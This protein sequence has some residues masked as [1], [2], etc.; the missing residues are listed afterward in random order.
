VSFGVK[1]C[2]TYTRSNHCALEGFTSF[3]LH[4]SF[5]GL[6]KALKLLLHL[7]VLQDRSSPSYCLQK[8]QK[9]GLSVSAR[10]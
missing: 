7:V 6:Q 4:Q 9:A 3:E 8:T 2:G 1:I 5:F 10:R